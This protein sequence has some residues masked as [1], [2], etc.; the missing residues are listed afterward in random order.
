APPYLAPGLCG[1]PATPA[2]AL[3]PGNEK[4]DY[5]DIEIRLPLVSGPLASLAAGRKAKVTLTYSG[6]T[7]QEDKLDVCYY[8]ENAKKWVK[9]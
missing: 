7:G 5:Y 9:K 4:S 3:K 1:S 2:D 6:A 8:D